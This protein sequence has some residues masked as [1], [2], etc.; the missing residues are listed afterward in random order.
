MI[1]IIGMTTIESNNISVQKKTY[2]IFQKNSSWE[3]KT[4]NALIVTIQ[5]HASSI[6]CERIHKEV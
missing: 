5:C 4:N 2:K 6:P 3:A 1:F